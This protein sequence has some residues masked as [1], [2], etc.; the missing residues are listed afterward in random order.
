LL[1]ALAT[2]AAAPAQTR[3]AAARTGR[4]A[5]SAPATSQP[6][7]SQPAAT[8]APVDEVIPQR[9]IAEHARKIDELI[10]DGYRENRVRPN[11]PIGHDEF[12][13][14]TYLNIAGR[15]ATYD[16]ARDF[17]ESRNRNKRTELINDLLDS[18]AYEHHQF[19]YFA[20]MLRLQSY[21]R[22]A[23]GIPYIKWIKQQLA[24]NRPYDEI[25]Y[26]LLTSEGYM[27]ENGAAGYY[28]RDLA[29]PLDNMSN[30]ARIF[31]GT[32]MECAQCHDHP[33]DVWTQLEYHE[34]AAFTYGTHTTTL[35][36][37][38]PNIEKFRQLVQREPP[39]AETGADTRL[40]AYSMTRPL[41]Y[42]VEYRPRP[43]TLPHD[44]KYDDADPGDVVHPATIFGNFVEP[45]EDDNA[46]DL[47]AKWL[48]SPENPRFTTVIANRM[49]A[50]VFGRGVI[51][52]LDD[53]RENSEPSNPALM[54][55]LTQMM[56]EFDY[57]LKQYLR[58]LYNTDVYQRAAPNRE[59]A[60]SEAYHFPGPLLRRMSA[61]QIW[62]SM[63]T[64][65]IMKPDERPGDWTDR[66][67]DYEALERMRQTD[68][69]ELLRQARALGRQRQEQRIYQQN[70]AKLRAEL[71]QARGEGRNTR[72]IERRIA[73][74]ETEWRQQRQQMQQS[75]S[76]MMMDGRADRGGSNEP[77]AEPG[78][79]QWE[80]FEPGLVR[81][82]ELPQPAPLGHFLRQFGQADREQIEDA[83]IEASVPQVLALVNGPVYNRMMQEYSV[84]VHNVNSRSS[85]REKIDVIFLSIL[86]RR[87]TPYEMTYCLREIKDWDAHGY[88]NI[89][90]S[91]LNTR[92]F[93]FIQ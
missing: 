44:Y 77:A 58:V 32:R 49:W 11:P 63:L 83:T 80:K 45:G 33:F 61:E 65:A 85:P 79:P 25:V 3:L 34:M 92:Q 52:P 13:R 5:S 47:Y 50:K 53:I 27:W 64:L 41:N 14:R 6:A 86:N 59:P 93:V 20:D 57:D 37:T 26:D 2:A 70:M 16:E 4:T 15:I 68:P 19:I 46:R 24:T 82:A 54:E 8:A 39:A 73:Q 51:E 69:E 31:L 91:L 42:R 81:A 40:A 62:D 71:S 84:L 18:K 60:V 88:G 76:T 23:P 12:L 17:L 55:Y 72:D 75:M 67:Y 78:H 35:P 1:I 28:Q 90:W 89:V 48:T 56:I 22:Y 36:G 74:M 38:N 10:R 29:M 9:V 66:A 21:L 30:T 87:P 43:L 7:T